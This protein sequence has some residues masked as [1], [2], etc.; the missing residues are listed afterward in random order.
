MPSIFADETQMTQL[1][2]NMIWYA[3]KFHVEEAPR[4]EISAIGKVDDW[5]FS[6]RDNGILVESLPGKGSTF[7]FTLPM[8]AKNA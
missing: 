1:F 6:V 8:D 3:L 5:I 2:Q 7:N 4:V